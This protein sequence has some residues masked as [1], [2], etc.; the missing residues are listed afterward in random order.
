MVNPCLCIR[1]RKVACDLSLRADK[2][3]ARLDRR[4]LFGMRDYLFYNVTRYSHAT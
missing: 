1:D 2:K 4:I 3:A